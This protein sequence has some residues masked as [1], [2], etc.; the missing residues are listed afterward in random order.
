MEILKLQ[1]RKWRW[2]REAVEVKSGKEEVHRSHQHIGAAFGGFCVE[3]GCAGGVTWENNMSTQHRQRQVCG[4]WKGGLEKGAPRCHNLILSACATEWEGMRANLAGLERLIE[5]PSV[6]PKNQK[7]TKDTKATISFYGWQNQ[8]EWCRLQFVDLL[9][10]L[11]H[12][13][14]GMHKATHTH[15]Q[16]EFQ[17]ERCN[18]RIIRMHLLNS[19]YIYLYL[20]V[21]FKLWLLLL[22]LIWPRKHSTAFKLSN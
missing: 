22:W 5:P 6:P 18:H 15:Y 2:K 20:S 12:S 21:I 13:I 3:N 7:N 10:H 1:R 14:S 19:I 4:D 11:T 16:V 9:F 8:E 17:V